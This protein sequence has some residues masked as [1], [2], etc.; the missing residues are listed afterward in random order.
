MRP[1]SKIESE[2][3]F[4]EFD[5]GILIG[6]LNALQLTVRNAMTEI[7][8]LA[9]ENV[10]DKPLSAK[11]KR[12]ARDLDRTARRLDDLGKVLARA[13]FPRVRSNGLPNQPNARFEICRSSD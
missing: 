4:F 2:R 7:A 5:R 8:M 1:G 12:K 9:A 10:F 6:Q 3:D 13:K 11:L